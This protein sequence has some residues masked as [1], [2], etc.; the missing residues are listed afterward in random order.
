MYILIHKVIYNL[1]GKIKTSTLKRKLFSAV[2][3]TALATILVIGGTTLAFADESHTINNSSYQSL[4]SYYNAN[5]TAM[6]SSNEWQFG[7][8]QINVGTS[9]NSD[10]EFEIPS[11]ITSIKGY[12]DETEGTVLNPYYYNNNSLTIKTANN[13][14]TTLDNLY[15]NKD[16]NGYTVKL[17]TGDNSNTTVKNSVFE[18][19]ITIS[20]GSTLNLTNS[21]I[22]A[23]M[24]NNGGN[25]FID[26]S[27][28]SN[29]NSGAKLE[30][31]TNRLDNGT[32]GTA[33]RSTINFNKSL[34]TNNA[35]SI[36]LDPTQAVV[37]TNIAGLTARLIDNGNGS[38]S[39][40]VEG[41]PTAELTNGIVNVALVYGNA[42]NG[43]FSFNI[44]YYVNIAAAQPSPVNPTNPV[45]NPSNPTSP[46]NNAASPSTT[47]ISSQSIKTSAP[48]TGDSNNMP[49][50][51]SVVIMSGL[52]MATLIYSRR[53]I[54][55][56]NK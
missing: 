37:N 4:Q 40:V 33:Y 31:T 32:V 11:N 38:Y 21:E 46:S 44:P 29:L 7:K 43:G 3:S 45:V 23:A 25:L 34:A 9:N 5:K 26:N 12:G 13:S 22:Y 42:A 39:V 47:N 24:T 14:S 20:S 27:K 1:G 55:N 49:I 17:K 36:Q 53:R 56:L 15:F 6:D 35:S 41:T 51:I 8:R 50:A 10:P 28:F 54:S 18:G 16:N 19:P 52:A 2:I 30:I 48:N